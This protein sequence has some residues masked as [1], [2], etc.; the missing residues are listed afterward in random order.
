MRATRHGT[1]FFTETNLHVLVAASVGPTEQLAKHQPNQMRHL[2]MAQAFDETSLR[3]CLLHQSNIAK[4]QPGQ[5][6]HLATAHIFACCI[7][8]IH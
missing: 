6:L 1:T 7:N 5:T 2:T 3:L 8:Q 4:Q